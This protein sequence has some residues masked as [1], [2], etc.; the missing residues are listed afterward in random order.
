MSRWAKVICG[1]CFGASAFGASLWGGRLVYAK[2][3]QDEH[4]SSVVV[5]CP[6]LT[7]DAFIARATLYGVPSND[8]YYVMSE[9][10]SCYD[11]ERRV[12]RWVLEYLTKDNVTTKNASRDAS[13]F[14]ADGAI[15]PHAHVDEEEMAEAAFI[16]PAF[17]DAGGGG[18]AVVE[19]DGVA[20]A[21][22][23]GEGDHALGL[24]DVV[25]DGLF[26]EDVAAGGEGFERGLAV[27]T[28][29]FVAAGGDGAEV[30]LERGEH[31]G[32]IVEGGDVEAGGGG[33]G[34][35]FLEVADADEFGEG[36]G[37]VHVG[38]TVADGAEAY[39]A[40]VEHFVKFRSRTISSA[41]DG[42]T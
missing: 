1:F 39:D 28:A 7:R 15:D 12:P 24:G 35:G 4:R 19:V 3:H 11:R 21:F 42:V 6:V 5:D 2:V 25:G 17:G 34:A 30:G 33:I 38:V 27:I 10:I 32:G 36:V 22:F 18:E 16:E 29:V 9:Y 20:A 23:A 8:P 14:Y 26:A 13:K 41:V 31:G 40:D 37:S